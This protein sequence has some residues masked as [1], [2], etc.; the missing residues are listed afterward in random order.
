VRLLPLGLALLTLLL[1]APSTADAA[2]LVS[3]G[4]FA[5]PL[6]VAAP[7]GDSE[8]LM[9]VEKA[10]AIRVWREGQ[11]SGLF[12]DV[13]AAVGGIQSAG[14]QGLLSMA[15]APDYASSGRFY[16][17]YTAADGQSNRIDEFRVSSDRSLAD[18]LSR[19]QVLVVPHTTAANH[20][21]GQI[22][23]GRDGLLYAAPGDG[24]NTPGQAQDASSLL[25]KVLRIDPRVSGPSCPA[26][27]T[28]CYSSPA[29]NPFAGATAG[30]DEIL[31]LGVR[32]PFRFSFDSQRSDLIIGDVGG[33]LQE[34]V[35]LIPKGTPG[36]RNLGWPSCEGTSCNGPIPTNYFA[37]ALSYAQPAPRAVTGGVVVRDP[38]LSKLRGRYLYADFYEGVIRSSKL[39]AQAGAGHGT[40]TGLTATF[41]ASITQD[42]GRCVYV[43]SLQG[44]VYRIAPDTRPVVTPCP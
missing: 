38:R 26:T 1:L 16:V 24:G 39:T 17:Y 36:G 6:Y 31:H 19:R 30:R 11:P 4:S 33:G 10:G 20:N 12:L 43:T 14:E 29:G 22:A 34:E 18:P 35:T 32:N 8:R 5:Q 25:G 15:F 23:F 40:P 37:P 42:N 9:V 3:L 2:R 21:G 7:P 41:L 28:D 44:G 27:P 13:A